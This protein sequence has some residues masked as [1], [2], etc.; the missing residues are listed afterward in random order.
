MH[1]CSATKSQQGLTLARRHQWAVEAVLLLGVL[2][3]LF[4]ARFELQRCHRYAV[5]KQGEIESALIAM[6]AVDQLWHHPQPVL[7]ISL[8]Q[9]WVK[10]MVGLEGGH[11]QPV[12]SIL[13]LMTE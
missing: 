13:Y 7:G 3:A 1:Q 6:G 11:R 4:E 9:L 5:Q 10:V 12:P 8:D 2:Q